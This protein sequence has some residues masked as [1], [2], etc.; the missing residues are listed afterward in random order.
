VIIKNVFIEKSLDNELKLLLIKLSSKNCLG[1]SGNTT[2]RQ[3]FELLEKEGPIENENG[4][5]VV[6]GFQKAYLSNTAGS[7]SSR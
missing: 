6:E 1:I 5:Y 3:L 4:F 7:L 2:I